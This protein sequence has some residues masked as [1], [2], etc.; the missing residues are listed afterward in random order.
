[1]DDVD[2]DEKWSTNWHTH[3]HKR[4]REQIKPSETLNNKK[5]EKFFIFLFACER[6]K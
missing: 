3:S 6:V 4:E 2:D 5:N 1:M